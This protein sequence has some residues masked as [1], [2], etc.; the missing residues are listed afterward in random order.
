VSFSQPAAGGDNFTAA[1]H[2]GHLLLIYP[3]LY[4]PEEQTKN[5]VSQAADVDIVV[6]DKPG[7]DGAPLV[8]RDARIF[9]NLARSVRNDVGGKVLG[10]LGQGPNTKGTPPWI[11]I[12]F[13]D[14]DVA[15]AT[16]VAAA[17]EAGQFGQP[18]Q[19]PMAQTPPQQQQWQATPPATTAGAAPAQWQGQPSAPATPPGAAPQQQWQAQQPPAGAYQ[20][21]QPPA[22]APNGA[23][24]APSTA[25]AAAP[26][27]PPAAAAASAPAAPAY[28][29]A[30]AAFLQSK[31]VTPPPDEATAR[32][33]AASFS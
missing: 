16:P 4:K 25:P 3:K 8:F 7:P 29:P 33:I 28:D 26:A 6:V 23:A 11:L 19:N 10:R 5:G 20:A 1:D 31:G 14:Q 18:A 24:W 32:A 9:G 15:T 27:P 17:F 13:S 2:N 21:P 22:P 12:N 30:L